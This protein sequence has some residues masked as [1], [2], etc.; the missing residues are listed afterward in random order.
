MSLSGL[1][2]LRDSTMRGLLAVLGALFIVMATAILVN[3]E[4]QVTESRL[5]LLV[6]FLFGVV[7]IVFA[8][9]LNGLA[10]RV[11]PIVFCVAMPPVLWGV[12]KVVCAAGWL[13]GATCA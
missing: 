12:S 7:L 8:A 3:H 9:L 1:F 5:I 11:A 2:L 10:L 13:S 4:W 6:P